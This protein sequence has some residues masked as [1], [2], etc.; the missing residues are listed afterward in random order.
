[1]KPRSFQ[2]T[3]RDESQRGQRGVLRSISVDST[4]LSEFRTH[5]ALTRQE[6]STDRGQVLAPQ[7]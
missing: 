1:M 5:H 2:E 7:S 4:S 3:T 6:R